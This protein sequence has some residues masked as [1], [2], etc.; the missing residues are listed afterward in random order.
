MRVSA[1]KLLKHKWLQQARKD[2]Q[3][4]AEEKKNAITTF[5]DNVQS[6]VEWNESIQVDTIGKMSTIKTIK[7]LKPNVNSPSSK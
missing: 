3:Q 1:S 6:I 2:R 4:T 5:S 7:M